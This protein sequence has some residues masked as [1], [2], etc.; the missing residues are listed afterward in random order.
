MNVDESVDVNLQLQFS[1]ERWVSLSEYLASNNALSEDI[2]RR[3]I[4][5]VEEAIVKPTIK[6]KIVIAWMDYV[7]F[8][9]AEYQVPT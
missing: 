3:S 8:Y 7:Q 1:K 4:G 9:V 2:F 6:E 5:Y